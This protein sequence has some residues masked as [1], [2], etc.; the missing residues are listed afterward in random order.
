MQKTMMSLCILLSVVTAASC[1]QKK[2]KEL[3]VGDA[4][5]AFSL[6]DQDGKL[7]NSADYI[8]KNWLVIFFYP[9]DESMVCTKEACAFRDMYAEFKEAGAVV[10]GINN[11]NAASHKSFVTNRKLPYPLLIDSANKTLHAF[12]VPDAFF[13]TGRK[14]FVI[15]KTGKIVFVYDAS[16]KGSK[17][18][19]E[20]LAYIKK[21]NG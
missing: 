8:G 16:L 17:H 10:A 19:E 18:A 13:M 4:I 1:Q 7:F 15:D 6:P 20:A 21:H 5:P 2:A 12:G 9:K 3:T 14:T 11:G